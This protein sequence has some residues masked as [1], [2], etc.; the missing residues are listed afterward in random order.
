MVTGRLMVARAD[1]GVR[2]AGRSRRE[3]GVGVA[4]IVAIAFVFTIALGGRG[5]SGIVLRATFS[6][7]DGL[8]IGSDVRIAGV[9]VGRVTAEVVDPKT[10]LATVSFRIRPDIHLTVDSSAAILSEGLLGGKYLALTPGGDP[11]TLVAGDI[12]TATQGSISLE[13]L[14]GKFIASV[15]SLMEQVKVQNAR[16]GGGGTK[17]GASPGGL[18][19]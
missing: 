19:P 17:A 6:H 15:E 7:V 18:D 9:T 4:V 12:I 1:I 11:R 10:F 13:A 16:L 14:L 5:S 2:D 8:G 3:F